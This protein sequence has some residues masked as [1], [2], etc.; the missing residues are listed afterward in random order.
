MTPE[1][2][3]DRALAAQAAQAEF[4][5]LITDISRTFLDA[6]PENVDAR[7]ER[8]LGRIGRF[9]G[10]D[11]AYVFVFE[12]GNLMT[13][14]HE[15]CEEGIH[16][17]WHEF[18]R[19]GFDRHPML[20]ER[21]LGGH[22][23][24]VP[25]SQFACDLTSHECTSLD[26]QGIRSLLAVP[27]IS[28]GRTIGFLGF[29]SVREP[30][31]WPA[32]TIALLRI[33]ADII[34]TTQARM[35]QQLQLRTLSRAIEQSPVAVV[36]TDAEGAVEYVNPRFTALTGYTLDDVRGRKPRVLMSG[37]SSEDDYQRMWDTVHSG[38][39]WHGTLEN[40]RK[41]GERY[42]A[43]VT[44]SAMR[45][46]DGTVT[47]LVGVQEDITA[48]KEAEEELREAKSQA[49]SANRAKS[50]FLATMSHE[51]RTPMNAII[52]MAEL[53]RDT[54]LTVQ[55]A[56]YVDI[57]Q[58][59]GESLL[60]LINAVLDLSKIEAD[61]LELERSAFDVREL[62]ETA[63]A[64]IGLRAADKGVELLFRVSPDVPHAIVGDQARLR[65]VLM[66]LLGNAV[67]FTDEGQI[68]LS[69]ERDPDTTAPGALLFRVEDTG[70]GIEPEKI[71][72]VFERFTQADS[73]TT[74][75]YGG[76]GLGLTISRRIVELMGGR[77]WVE[78][79]PGEGT[80]FLFTIVFDTAEEPAPEAHLDAAPMLAGR[81][82]LVVD[83]NETNRMIVLETV[84]PWGVEARQAV[85]AAE[86]LGLLREAVHAGEPF[87][88]LVLDQQMPEADG[89]DLLEQ[90]RADPEIAGVPAIMFSSDARGRN[91]E[92][93][94]TLGLADYLLKPVRRGELR[95]A[96][97]AALVS[98]PVP[99]VRAAAALA[100]G[101]EGPVCSLRILL[102]E[103]TED[104]RFLIRHYLSKSPHTLVEVENGQEALD[105]VTGSDV[106]FDLVLM[107]MQMPVMDGYEATRQIR[108]WER[109]N[110]REP[111]KIVALTAYALKE[112]VDR[113]LQAGCDGH[114]T[115]PI[116]K[117]TLLE[118]IST[119][120]E[121]V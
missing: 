66:N 25:D 54:E 28:E 106:P 80:T 100:G 55:Q 115:K 3:E 38:R 114:L 52:G 63:G 94:K 83:D 73:S 47:H 19:V 104:N 107:D 40:V 113:S 72:A 62:A 64:V 69:I 95:D 39:E 45:A 112:E 36:I 91:S 11:R 32:E 74:R 14:T 116:K 87:D 89:F 61:K 70:I 15:W 111:L 97:S 51:I 75:K 41:T 23:A 53:L 43:S 68:L 110:G 76:T 88:V 16:S 7:I 8:S 44:F 35:S 5:A 117:K 17:R 56:R 1:H 57:F 99:G 86:A 65:Q 10:V 77:M 78:S 103:D 102:A 34:A 92:R 29:D 27:M 105:A 18:Q 60:E 109:E 4:N 6:T 37:L 84:T 22:D 82:L 90:V 49:E 118:G 120:T 9:S 98:V 79:R 71:A 96:L 30:K 119:Y 21:L 31:E 33:V 13:N 101:T 85:S 67:K 93:A 26:T 42:W 59:A 24:H 50:E 12:D 81:R 58:R 108:A 20:T 121:G 2:A 46:P 48:Q